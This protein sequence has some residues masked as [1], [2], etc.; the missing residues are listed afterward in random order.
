[1]T[2][3]SFWLDFID[4][5]LFIIDMNQIMHDVVERLINRTDAFIQK[6]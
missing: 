1:M 2:Q 5:I 6:N 4:L 3:S